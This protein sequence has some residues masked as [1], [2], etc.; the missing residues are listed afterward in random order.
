MRFSD[1]VVFGAWVPCVRMWNPGPRHAET[2]IHT[3]NHITGGVR[4]CLPEFALLFR[5]PH[6][7]VA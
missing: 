1:A 6:H 4:N 7:G 2:G 5:R 3:L